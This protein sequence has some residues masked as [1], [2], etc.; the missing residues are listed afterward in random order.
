[1][2]QGHFHVLCLGDSIIWGQGLLDADKFTTKLTAWINQYH[3]DKHAFKEVLAHSGAVIGVGSTT[4]VKPVN[5][6]VPK[7]FPS[8]L[9]QC[10][11]FAGDPA[12]VDLVIVNGGINDLGVQYIFS[13]FTDAEELADTT[14]RFCRLDLTA[15]LIAIA[16]RFPN[17]AARIL[18][19]GYYP[20]L[21]GK[22]D[23]L[24]I[25]TI[26]PLFG[27][28]LPSFVFPHNPLAKV[29]SN[30]LLFW[31]KSTEAMSSA[32]AAANAAVGG[33]RIHFVDAGFAE[34]NS[35]FGPSPWVYAIRAD[36]SPQDSVIASRR[37]S[38]LTDEHDLLQREFCFRASVGHPNIAGADAIFRA[39]YPKMQQLYGF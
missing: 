22:S 10:A 17:P 32:V 20:V 8:I 3:P 36:L 39:L 15:L 7:A 18:V 25:P 19:P 2:G 21:S 12:D 34:E 30:S 1:M 35:A 28:T 38:C 13:P 4:H 37:A 26:L 11:A 29:V 27:V 16:N 5:G 6:E 14:D 23:L 31:H 33:Q 24:R 9:Q